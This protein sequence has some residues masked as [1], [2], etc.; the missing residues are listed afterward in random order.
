MVGSTAE[1][2]FWINSQ[3]GN[4]PYQSS[5]PTDKSK[6]TPQLSIAATNRNRVSIKDD[7][8]NTVQVP[9]LDYVEMLEK[10]LEQMDGV[11]RAQKG[12]ITHLH[13]HLV[14]AH[15]TIEKIKH[16]QSLGYGDEY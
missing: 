16:D 8:G 10:K 5:G 9:S 13:G 14:D 12:Q 7:K 15:K 1:D 3:Y 4:K 11:I 6:Q 2:Y